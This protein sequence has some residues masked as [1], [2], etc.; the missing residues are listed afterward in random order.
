M[1]TATKGR[2]QSCAQCSAIYRAKQTNS[3]YCSRRCIVRAQRGAVPTSAKPKSVILSLLLRLSMVGNIGPV[4]CRDP[5]PAVL[6]LTVPRS[7]AFVELS[8]LFDRKGW[9]VLS[10]AE[11]AAELKAHGVAAYD[12]APAALRKRR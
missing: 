10:E 5:R 12:E 6:G 3:R 7:Y 4:N 1:T 9:G 8:A 2:E 11:F